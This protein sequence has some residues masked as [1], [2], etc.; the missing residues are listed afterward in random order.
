MEDLVTSLV[1]RDIVKLTD[2][3]ETTSCPSAVPQD[4]LALL[5]TFLI[6]KSGCS[7]S[8]KTIEWLYYLVDQYPEALRAVAENFGDSLLSMKTRCGS[9]QKLYEIR[10]KLSLFHQIRSEVPEVSTATPEQQLEQSD[11]DSE[12][13]NYQEFS[14]IFI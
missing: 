10:G 1:E 5:A 13:A 9:I 6:Q 11:E 4:Y 14:V 7:S 12:E 3:I 2:L 8:P